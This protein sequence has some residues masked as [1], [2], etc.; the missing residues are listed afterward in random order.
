MRLTG[1]QELAEGD[2]LRHIFEQ[3][4]TGKLNRK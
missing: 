2:S 4:I 1:A 3:Q